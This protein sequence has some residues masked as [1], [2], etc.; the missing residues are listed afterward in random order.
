MAQA[1]EP[2]MDPFFG[3]KDRKPRKK[4]ANTAVQAEGPASDASMPISKILAGIG[5]FVFMAGGISLIAMAA[6]QSNKPD[7]SSNHKIK[8]SRRIENNRFKLNEPYSENKNPLTKLV[9]PIRRNFESMPA[10]S[11][12]NS[13]EKPSAAPASDE[14]QPASSTPVEVETPHETS[15]IADVVDT[16]LPSEGEAQVLSAV[17]EESTNDAGETITSFPR[18]LRD[19]ELRA[20][21]PLAV[22]A[23]PVSAEQTTID[24]VRPA[25][26]S[27]A[28]NAEFG[29]ITET[30]PR[31][32]SAED[33][34]KS[35]KSVST[36]RKKPSPKGGGSDVA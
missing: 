9:E 28:Q 23:E 6:R 26:P 36:K 2:G 22:L 33:K 32:I 27:Q 16:D 19:N 5:M 20:V 25:E 10:D 14:F 11:L 24:S 15:G 35:A 8:K 7:K 31:L 1:E 30:K 29:A 17:N 13:D 4:T 12:V 3:A 34:T 18:P 21:R